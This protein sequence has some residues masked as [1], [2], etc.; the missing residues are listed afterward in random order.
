MTLQ[1]TTEIEN[2][3]IECINT[4][5]QYIDNS[6]TFFRRL[7]Y[8]YIKQQ[9][10]R[11]NNIIKMDVSTIVI[12]N[13]IFEILITS[14][15]LYLRLTDHSFIT[16]INKACFR[17]LSYESTYISPIINTILKYKE[18]YNIEYQKYNIEIVTK[19]PSENII[20]N[21]LLYSRSLNIN[22]SPNIQDEDN[23][24]YNELFEYIN[25]EYTG[26][27]IDIAVEEMFETSIVNYD[28]FNW[29]NIRLLN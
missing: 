2:L 12:L 11:L 4:H 6:L 16:K 14:I 13:N 10:K 17:I 18:V 20:N 24:M 1:M 8:M 5:L 22:T 15:A 29:S 25:I 27:S 23:E 3:I 7:Y 28:N 26:I 9:N 21:I 19:K